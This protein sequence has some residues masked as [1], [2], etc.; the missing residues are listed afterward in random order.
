MTGW[1]ISESGASVGLDQHRQGTATFTVTNSGADDDRAVLT[2]TP[3]DGAEGE[4][5]SVE[6]PQREVPSGGSAVY[7]VTVEVPEGAKPGSYGFQAVAYSADRDP[8]ESSV[9]SRRVSFEVAEPEPPE[10]FPWWVVA[11]VVAVVLVVAGVFW[12]LTRG[13]PP[14]NVSRPTI[15]AA[16]TQVGQTMFASPGEWDDADDL[17]IQWERCD[18]EVEVD[19]CSRL[20]GFTGEAYQ[21]TNA[22]VGSRMRVRVIARNSAGSTS[23]TSVL[24]PVVVGDPGGGGDDGTPPTT[25]TTFTVPTTDVPPTTRTIPPE[26]TTTSRPFDPDRPT[27]VLD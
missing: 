22:D 23:A 5:F 3:L 1:Q 11:A 13:D 17:E 16:G 6:E 15:S 27:T 21:L 18:D 4:W 8:G 2:V 26:L 9:T 12:L 25:G 14:T 10:P 19:R 7:V 20:V 24:T